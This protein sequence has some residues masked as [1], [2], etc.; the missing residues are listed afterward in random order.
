MNTFDHDHEQEKRYKPENFETDAKED[1]HD[2][3]DIIDDAVQNL[4]RWSVDHDDVLNSEVLEMFELIKR[5]R[6]QL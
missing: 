2:L 3:I 1:A 6:R 5:C 4:D